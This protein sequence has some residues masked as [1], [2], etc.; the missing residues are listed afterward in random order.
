[1]ASGQGLEGQAALVTGASRGI[2]RAIAL[3]LAA[4]GADV[5]VNFVS[6][7]EAAREVAA[8]IEAG[9]RRAVVVQGDV[10]QPVQAD[11]VVRATV[12]A[13]GRIDLLVNNAGI[14]R[15]RLIYE[16]NASDWQEVM[17]VN[18][19]GV[20]NCTRAALEYMMPQGAGTIIN[21]SSVMAERAWIGNAAYSAAKAAVNSFTRCAAVELARF[22]IRVYAVLPGF[23]GTEMVAPLVG[24]NGGESIIEQIPMRSIGT[25]EQ[26]ARVV[27]FLATLR[28]GYS[29]GTLFPIDGGAM[30]GLGV[31][32]PLRRPRTL[33]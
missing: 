17:A 26:V 19:G 5:V 12:A 3:E 28:D 31:A 13:L 32:R 15:D 7:E 1:M 23:V 2:G 25:P 4:L 14:A 29:T 11:A 9:G 8:E 18:F 33:K 22:G 21:I 24:A 20:F 10:S 6:Q 30:A 27:G 16:M